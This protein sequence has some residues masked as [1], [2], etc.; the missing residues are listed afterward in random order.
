[1]S[2][3]VT[4][5]NWNIPGIQQGIGLKMFL[6]H[7]GIPFEEKLYSA[8]LIKGGFGPHWDQSHFIKDQ[9]SLKFDFPQLPYLLQNS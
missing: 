7:A 1:M 9:R 8:K 5:G 3:K 2:E 6:Q 4:I